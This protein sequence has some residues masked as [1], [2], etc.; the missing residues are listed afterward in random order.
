VDRAWRAWRS[1]LDRHGP[2][3]LVAEARGLREGEGGPPVGRGRA[4]ELYALALEQNP[5]LQVRRAAREV[6]DYDVRIA[7]SAYLPSFS[8][9]TGLSGF[10]QQPSSTDLFIDQAQAQVLGRIASCESTND[11]Y[12]RLADPLPPLDCSGLAFTDADRQRIIDQNSGFP[13]SFVRTS[14]SVSFS[15]S[16]PIFQGLGRQRQVEAAQ[17]ARED[18]DQQIRSQELALQADIAIGVGRVETAY[19]SALIEER[20]Q[21][22][23][24][25]QLRLARE[26]YRVGL[27][28]FLDL[29]NA[30]TVKAEADQARLSAV[31][32]YHDS[33]T[34]LEAIVGAPLRS[35]TGGND[36]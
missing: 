35:S 31:F 6:S 18:A 2:L 10:T 13:F 27:I 9:S 20:N 29:V 28:N 14:P 7:K 3:H 22:L 24:D 15:L 17:V 23:A 25:E 32:A 12:S 26:Q 36:S 34:D 5:T 30:E 1:D 19:E 8:V 16:V 21:A 33:I 11:L 4:D